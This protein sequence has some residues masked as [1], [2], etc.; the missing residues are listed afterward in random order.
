MNIPANVSF[1]SAD[2]QPFVDPVL[3]GWSDLAQIL[4]V[5]NDAQSSEQ[6]QE[7][8]QSL[9]YSCTTAPDALSA[10]RLIAADSTIGIV[11]VELGMEA[12]DGA[13]LLNE[14]SERFSISRP[15]ISVAIGES[16]SDFTVEIVR[17]GA[18][19]FLEKPLLVNGLSNCL[20]RAASRWSRLAQQFR[21]T[22]L[23]PAGMAQ[24]GAVRTGST[25]SATDPSFADL[26]GLGM[27][28]MKSR[29]G[30]ANFVSEDLMCEAAWGI[31]LDLAVA[32]LKGERVAT[33]SAC[34]AAQV[35]LSTALRHVNQ[36][37]KAGWVKRVAD[38]K[39]KRRTYIKL[40]PLAFDQMVKYLRFTWDVFGSSASPVRPAPGRR[41]AA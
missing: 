3:S 24:I 26:Q 8:I 33:S 6:H 27:K 5:A 1:L 14:I 13:F 32:G 30:R 15:I 39:D 21:A 31:L 20:R 36:L 9:G 23:H 18:S 10:L 19:D 38:P 2:I 7:L 28:I 4:V 25:F 22:A 12:L 40:Q 17:A 11:L 37:I 35:P 16:S 29:Q 41:N 34:A